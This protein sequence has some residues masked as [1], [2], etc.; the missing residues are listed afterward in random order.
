M[1]RKFADLTWLFGQL[2]RGHFTIFF[3]HVLPMSKLPDWLYARWEW[4]V[5]RDSNDVPDEFYLPW[6]LY[7][8]GRRQSG[9]A[10]GWI[11]QEESK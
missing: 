5:M 4:L 9:K 2:L 6:K 1:K 10:F 7:W 3:V 8:K 11:Q